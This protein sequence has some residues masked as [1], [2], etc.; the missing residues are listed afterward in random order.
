MKSTGIQLNGIVWQNP[1]MWTVWINGERI[2]SQQPH[3]PYEIINV[4][5]N[6]VQVRLP[7]GQILALKPGR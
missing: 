5:E 4:T 3:P 6:L 2:T 7:D 1:Q